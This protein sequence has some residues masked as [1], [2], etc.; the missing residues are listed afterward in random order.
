MDE[1]TVADA[2]VRW[3]VWHQSILL[4]FCRHTVNTA[5]LKPND[6]KIMQNKTRGGLIHPIVLNTKLKTER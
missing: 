1:G 2:I 4:L 3:C 5:M 6:S